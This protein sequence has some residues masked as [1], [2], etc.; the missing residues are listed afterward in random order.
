MLINIDPIFLHFEGLLPVAQGELLHMHANWI[1]LNI[2]G[3]KDRVFVLLAGKYLQFLPCPNF[4]SIL[5]H[6]DFWW[7]SNPLLWTIRP[8][9]SQRPYHRFHFCSNIFSSY[10]WAGEYHY[11]HD[12]KPMCHWKRYKNTDGVSYIIRKC[13]CHVPDL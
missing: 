12:A 2:V 13:F 5:C 6:M 10:E 1:K 7:V 8:Y 3:C 4:S 9:P 11:H